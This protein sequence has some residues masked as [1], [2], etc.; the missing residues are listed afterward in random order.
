MHIFDT[1]EIRKFWH[2]I[3]HFS[4]QDMTDIHVHLNFILKLRKFF[5]KQR[6]L[7]RQKLSRWRVHSR[8]IFQ[9]IFARSL[10]IHDS[11]SNILQILHMAKYST[12][13]GLETKP[14]PR[15]PKSLSNIEL[16]LIFTPSSHVTTQHRVSGEMFFSTKGSVWGNAVPDENTPVKSLFI[17]GHVE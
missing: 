1:W 14:S 10:M 4:L 6:L 13:L 2:L 3:N 11:H 5:L 15:N 7:K 8:A 16:L 12:L 9:Y 17:L